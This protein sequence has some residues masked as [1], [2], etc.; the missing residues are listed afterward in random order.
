MS[1]VNLSPV[2]VFGFTHDPY[3]GLGDNAS[4]NNK[5][6]NPG[7]VTPP[8][9]PG[10]PPQN[11]EFFGQAAMTNG[12]KVFAAAQTG[13]PIATAEAFFQGLSARTGNFVLGQLSIWKD[14][15]VVLSEGY[16][17]PISCNDGGLIGPDGRLSITALAGLYVTHAGNYPI[18]VEDPSYD[19]WGTPLMFASGMY[20]YVAG[21]GKKRRVRIS[22]LGLHLVPRDFEP[23]DEILKN[24][25]NGPGN[26]VISGPFEHNIFDR[27]VADVWAAGLLGRVRGWV[28]GDLEI[29]ADHSYHFRGSFSL[30]EDTYDVGASNRPFIQEALTSFLEGVGNTLGHTNYQIEIVGSEPV[31]G[32]GVRW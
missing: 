31:E 22:S 21:G 13:D 24:A 8:G 3:Y 15:Q 28:N 14:F 11:P 2:P 23:V 10:L 25:L 30:A 20:Y 5:L 9:V 32:G 27:G 19:F 16:N 26:Y 7:P 6:F 18:R 29:R 1:A 17:R 12:P 4:Y